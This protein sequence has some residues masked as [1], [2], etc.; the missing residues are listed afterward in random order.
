MEPTAPKQ[1]RPDWSTTSRELDRHVK[2]ALDRLSPHLR[3][4][5]VLTVLQGLPAKDVATIEDCPT[6][7]IYW[8]VHQARRQLRKMLAE[9]LD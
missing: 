1:S 6:A 3:S 4:A 8:R 2:A 9:F 5:L 7:T